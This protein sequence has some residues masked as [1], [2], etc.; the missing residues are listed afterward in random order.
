MVKEFIIKIRAEEQKRVEIEEQIRLGTYDPHANSISKKFMRSLTLS[1]SLMLGSPSKTPLEVPESSSC[2]SNKS[3]NETEV[4][5]G[6]IKKT[7]ITIATNENEQHSQFDIE[8]GLPM[9]FLKDN[10]EVNQEESMP[11]E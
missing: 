9:H 5:L 8:K 2:F 7:E 6:N 1:L 11:A 3:V 10:K 4:P